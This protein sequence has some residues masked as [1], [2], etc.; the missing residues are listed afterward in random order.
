MKDVYRVDVGVLS[1]LVALVSKVGLILGINARFDENVSWNIVPDSSF[2]LSLCNAIVPF[3]ELVS[4]LSVVTTP[5]RSAPA[6][7]DYHEYIGVL[8]FSV[9]RLVE[10]HIGRVGNIAFLRKDRLVA[11]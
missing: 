2:V 7:N 11:E 10:W 4:W 9:T 8:N 3:K 5:L 1:F 6:A